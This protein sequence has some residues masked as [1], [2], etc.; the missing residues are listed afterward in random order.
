MISLLTRFSFP[1]VPGDQMWSVVDV[2]GP[3]SYVDVTPGSPGP[4]LVP[5]TGGQQLLPQ[6]FGLQ[7]LLFVSA[8]ASFDGLFSVV[9]IPQPANDGSLDRVILQWIDLSTGAEVAAGTDLSASTVRVFCELG[10]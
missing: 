9:A 10:Y 1:K 2:T 7:M 3:A 6:D 5:P 4:P 8:M